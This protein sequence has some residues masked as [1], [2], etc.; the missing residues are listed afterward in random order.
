MECP[1]NPIF[2][3]RTTKSTKKQII[4]KLDLINFNVNKLVLYIHSDWQLIYLHSWKTIVPKHKFTLTF[5]YMFLLCPS[6]ICFTYNQIT[7]YKTRTENEQQF[8]CHVNNVYEVELSKQLAWI[9][10]K[11]RANTDYTMNESWINH[12]KHVKVADCV[13]IK[14][15]LSAVFNPIHL[16]FTF[17][18]PTI[19]VTFLTKRTTCDIAMIC[20][21]FSRR[22]D[23]LYLSINKQMNTIQNTSFF[24]QAHALYTSTRLTDLT[25]NNIHEIR[26]VQQNK[27]DWISLLVRATVWYIDV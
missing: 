16:D 24:A 21:G 20:D 6:I 17:K 3:I 18:P 10:R 2:L 5:V 15:I 26:C 11:K 23:W 19:S 12:V 7:I 27:L 1:F 9:G 14:S 22:L 8:S 4:P 25:D 13:C